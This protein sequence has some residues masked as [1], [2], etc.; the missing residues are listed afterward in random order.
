[1]RIARAMSRGLNPVEP[2][3][4]RPT[5]YLPQIAPIGGPNSSSGLC[6]SLSNACATIPTNGIAG[7]TVLPSGALQQLAY[8]L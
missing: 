8:H 6:V 5:A 2:S 3:G 4:A 1:M 7:P